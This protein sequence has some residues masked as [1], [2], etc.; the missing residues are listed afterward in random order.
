MRKILKRK[1][2]SVGHVVEE[3]I[4]YK[5][6]SFLQIMKYLLTI[7]ALSWAC[8]SINCLYTPGDGVV[9]LTQHNFQAKVIDSSDVWLVEFYAPW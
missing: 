2:I 5:C 4:I 8:V 9:D 7:I 6:P 3:I 1:F